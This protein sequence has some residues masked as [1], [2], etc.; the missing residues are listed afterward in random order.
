M[1][2]PKKKETLTKALSKRPKLGPEE[3][4]FRWVKDEAEASAV[5]EYELGRE[6]L[7]EARY[8][9]KS[10]TKYNE[11][12]QCVTALRSNNFSFSPI[13]HVED[14]QL[15]YS[16]KYLAEISKG[17]KLKDGLPPS[18]CFVKE[19][20]RKQ[21]SKA[22]PRPGIL[23]R[24][25]ILSKINPSEADLPYKVIEIIISNYDYPTKKVAK[26]ILN[27]WV[28]NSKYFPEKESGRPTSSLIKLAAYRYAQRV[29]QGM[30]IQHDFVNALNL[31]SGIETNTESRLE[32]SPCGNKLYK[33]FLKKDGAAQSS[34][35]ED[36]N[37]LR[38]IIVEKVGLLTPLL[39]VK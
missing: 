37:F 22:K 9:L 3:W 5:Y 4:D 2:A 36:I 10:E 15:I 6:I 18:S 32:S 28:D 17:L 24:K 8:I 14:D 19:R 39:M 31:K 11:L 25:R 1:A 30:N 23:I 29:P 34:W 12:L 27:K 33:K 21:F 35:S 13:I 26:Q 16:L 7:R 20:I 38:N